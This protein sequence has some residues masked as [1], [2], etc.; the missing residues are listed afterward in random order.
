M[1]TL[2]LSKNGA[3]G[4]DN[5][6]SDVSTPLTELE[7]FFN[8]TKINYANVQDFGL[9]P[10]GLR[11]YANV[12]GLYA[13]IRNNSG[14]SLNANDQVYITGSYDDGTDVYPAVAKAVVTQARSTT[15]YADGIIH[16]TVANNADGTMALVKE[17]TSLNTNSLSIN[18]HIWLSHTAGSYNTSRTDHPDVD[19]LKQIVGRVS[20]VSAT[21]GRILFVFPGIVVP[22]SI[23]Q[24]V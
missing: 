5:F 7:T 24:E 14:G 20:K 10:G 1:P 8:T 15:Y 2:T 9:R 19:Y 22:W 4:E 6:W 18:A 11:T 16:A 23:A 3:D 12:E 17:V 13:K 21:D